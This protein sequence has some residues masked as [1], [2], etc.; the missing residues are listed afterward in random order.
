MLNDKASGVAPEVCWHHKSIIYLQY[1]CTQ[2][3]Q[4]V[5]NAG[6]KNLNVK[7]EQGLFVAC[8]GILISLLYLTCCYYLSTVASIEFKQW[9][10]GTVTASDFTVEYQIPKVVW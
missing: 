9:D 3:L 7:R 4:G 2:P 1:S 6:D 8:I 5:D 10:V